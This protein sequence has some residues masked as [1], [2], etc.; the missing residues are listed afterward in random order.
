MKLA[1]NHDKMIFVKRYFAESVV[2]HIMTLAVA[3]FFFSWEL[4]AFAFACMAV[5]MYSIGIFHHM[6][7][8]HH[9]FKAKT[10][11]LYLGSLLGTLALR[12]PTSSPIRYAAMHRAHHAYSDTPLDPHTPTKGIFFAYVLWFYNL[13]QGFMDKKS[14]YSYA[15]A[16]SKNGFY[17][18]L[19]TNV[20]PLQ[21][22]WALL[23]FIVAG[24]LGATDGQTFSAENDFAYMIYGTFV[25]SFLC[26]YIGNLVDVVNHVTGYRNYETN[27]QSRNTFWLGLIHGGGAIGW[28]NNHH[29]H[30]GYF[31][32]KKNWWEH[33]VYF[34]IMKGLG[35]FGLVW[36]I[37]VLDET[38]QQ[39]SELKGEAV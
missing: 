5:F 26:Y 2:V 34:S 7:H 19:D 31:M 14:Y 9:T 38:K 4:A 20:I 13:H 23:V 28:H 21:I 39:K 32:V 18:F 35:L 27:D 15:P 22:I 8:S 29:A 33:D 30:P 3:P 11:V 24:L 16:S 6:Y 12:G 36:D 17:R 25:K 1:K 37:K 10:W